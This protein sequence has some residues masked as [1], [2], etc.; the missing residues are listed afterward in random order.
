VA[1]GGLFRPANNAGDNKMVV[2]GDVADNATATG[3][4]L[5]PQVPLSLVLFAGEGR[6]R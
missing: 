2:L 5:V 3:W 6:A 4:R 1:C